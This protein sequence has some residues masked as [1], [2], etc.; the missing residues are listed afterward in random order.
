MKRRSFDRAALAQLNDQIL[1]L[2]AQG[3]QSAE[4]LARVTGFSGSTIRARLSELRLIGKAHCVQD[5]S[6]KLGA[7]FFWHAGAGEGV[8][9]VDSPALSLAT[10]YQVTLKVYPIE[11]RRDPLV[12]ALFGPANCASVQVA[13]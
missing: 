2:L 1:E 11:N 13:A 3:Q 5:P 4:G 12:A 8:R 9:T 6:S 7:R 10:A